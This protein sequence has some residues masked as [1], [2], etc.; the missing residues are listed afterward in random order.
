[1]LNDTA[2]LVKCI[3]LIYKESLLQESFD[4]KDIVRILLDSI[5]VPE[6]GFGLSGD[7]EIISNLK[8]VA[9]EMINNSDNDYCREDLLQTLK[10]STLSNDK[11]FSTIESSLEEDDEKTLKRNVIAIRKVINS[12]LKE[13]KINEILNKASYAY[14][15]QRNEIKDTS[16]FISE[17][18]AQ[19]EPLQ[20][21]K[22]NVD[23]AI[24]DSV[25]IGDDASLLNTL[26]KVLDN[27]VS[28]NTYRTGWID[29][30]DMLQGGVRPGEFV[31]V[32][33][34]QHKYK[35][36]FTLSL[37]AQL[38][39]YNTPKTKDISKKPLL[40]RISFE[41]DLDSN[42]Q[43]L[44]Q[45]LKYNE[46]KE[47]VKITDLKVS[48]MAV[49]IREKLQATGFNI[50]M[51]RIDPTQWTYRDLCSKL[52]EYEST[53][54]NIEI[55]MIDYLSQLPTTGCI[56]TG[57]TGTDLRDLY[58]RVR[59]YCSAKDICIITPHQLSTDAKNLLR[60]GIPG[61]EFVKEIAE[62]GYFSGSKQLD[63]EVD[64][65]LYIHP[66]QHNKE[67]FLSVQLGK[68]RLPT[69]VPDDLKYF[70]MKFTSKTM[71]VLENIN[72]VNHI[73]LRKP[74]IRAASTATEDL[75]TL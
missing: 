26:G 59:N 41:D 5:K 44:Y 69:R 71:P 34:L 46:T 62:K 72:D 12:H 14:K 23:S 17:L 54:Y 33:A 40:L 52:Q 7:R 16:K 38:A 8:N 61:G 27:G 55:L 57:P 49:Y 53:G 66:F 19:L 10:I 25:D 1:L 29:L 11:L 31:M 45:Y 70:L 13:I 39:M 28:T 20:A 2:L 30:N 35:T 42:M 75:Y 63:Q 24:M 22:A 50:K 15:F 58:R 9:Y 64:V 37:F 36:G 65:E 74:P 51:I 47:H 32:N 56:S 67:T 6:G 43:F 48:D 3:S 60:S 18:I 73:A 4:S 68:H 21:D